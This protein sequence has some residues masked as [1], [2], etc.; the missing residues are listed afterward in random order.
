MYSVLSVASL[1]PGSLPLGLGQDPSGF[2]LFGLKAYRW[3]KFGFPLRVFRKV[4]L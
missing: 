1:L 2:E 4:S 3:R